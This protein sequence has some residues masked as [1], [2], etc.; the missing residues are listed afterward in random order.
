MDSLWQKSLP[1]IASGTGPNLILGKIGKYYQFVER[2][3]LEPYPEEYFPSIWVEENLPNAPWDALMYDGQYY[4]FPSAY[5]GDLLMYNRKHFEE[6]GLDPDNPPTTWD[7]LI[8][9][10]KKLTKTDASGNITRAG[11]VPGDQFPFLTYT[12]QLGGNIIK[13]KEDGT[14]VANMNSPEVLEAFKFLTDFYT[15]HDVITPE[16]PDFVEAIGTESAS[17]TIGEIYQI[18]L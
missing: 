8:A 11:F 16:F 6:V 15:K 3:V 17:M 18:Y 14:R 9:V 13:I 12:Y 4:V 1:A 7:E 5:M 10:A 2:G